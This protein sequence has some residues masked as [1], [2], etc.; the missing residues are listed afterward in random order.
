MNKSN[1][2]QLSIIEKVRDL[3]VTNNSY[4]LEEKIPNNLM[5]E[6]TNMCNLKCNM[7]YNKHMKRKK[8]F[9]AFDLYKRIV[10][11][12]HELKIE[13]LGLYTTGESFLHPQIFNF[14][15]YAKQKGIKYVYITTNG[16]TLNNE[17]IEEIL[18]SGL[19]SIKFSI[20]AGNKDQ[21]ESLKPGADWKKLINIIKKLRASRD[22]S[23]NKLK[24]FA[25]FIV[26]KNNYDD[27]INYNH[28]FGNLID[29]TIYTL[30]IN[31][32]SQVNANN[33]YP[34]SIKSIVDDF[35]LPESRWHPCSFLW[36]R[37][38][39]TYEGYLTIC[40][41]DFE[42][43]LVYGDLN[44]E[45]LENCWNN[46]KMKKFRKIHKNKEFN[47]LSMCS[48]CDNIKRNKNAIDIINRELLQLP[49]INS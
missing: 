30:I 1:T 25:S 14:I 7:C 39:T 31:Q 21:Y 28:I 23:K 4:P 27:L 36:N 22:G 46:E 6:V 24:I 47:K 5:I 35:I 48:N 8:G 34:E 42:N 41:I 44:K 2:N 15:K 40:C 16:Q 18:K 32:G 49:H 17:K 45:S 37:F 20:D 10:D 11:Q 19:D 3:Y 12:A 26:M 9:M 13:N 38:I 29:E 33:L 43:Q